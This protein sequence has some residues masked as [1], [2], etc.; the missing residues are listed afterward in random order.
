MANFKFQ[1]FGQKIRSGVMELLGKKTMPTLG[2]VRF[3]DQQLILDKKQ[4]PQCHA[5][6]DDDE[7]IKNLFVCVQ[8]GYHFRIDAH[9]RFSILFDG[10]IYEEISFSAAYNNPIDYPEYEVKLRKT[11]DKSGEDEAVS[12]AIGKIVDKDIVVA[13]MSFSF[14]GGSM[15]VTVGE[16]ILQA[17]FT[18]INRNIP[19]MLITASGGARM[20]EGLFSLMQMARTSHA[21]A[22]LEQ[23]RLPLFILF[24]DPTTGGVS[25]SFAMLGNIILA[26]PNALIGFAGPRVIEGTIKHKLPEGFQRSEFQLEKGFVD[27]IVQRDTLR[28]VLSYLIDTHKH[29]KGK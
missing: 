8:C 4:C 6:F 21:I 29:D 2:N 12:V 27:A 11:K 14:L 22:L 26:E 13:C 24:T 10:G 1:E 5:H 3:Q 20:Y 9:T 23:A 25:A 16:R 19:C 18:A 17:I 15:G 28:K 7:Q